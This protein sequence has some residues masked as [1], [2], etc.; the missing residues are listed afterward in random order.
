MPPWIPS[1]E[2]EALIDVTDRLTDI[3]DI[4][5]SLVTFGVSFLTGRILRK[6]IKEIAGGKRVR[7]GIHYV[8]KLLTESSKVR[9]YNEAIRVISKNKS[10][11]RYL[12]KRM[13]LLLVV[14]DIEPFHGHPNGATL[15]SP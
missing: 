7:K 14:N 15:W 13:S 5:F 2:E 11:V 9:H 1:A 3:I 6:A 12:E 8:V 4:G 10:A